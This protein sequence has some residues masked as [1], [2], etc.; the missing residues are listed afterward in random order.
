MYN[1]IQR[2]YQRIS[3]YINVYQ[4]TFI[5]IYIYPQ[6]YQ[7]HGTFQVRHPDTAASSQGRPQT[8]AK[9]RRCAK[10]KRLGCRCW[11]YVEPTKDEK[12]MGFFTIIDNIIK[13]KNIYI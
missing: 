9:P 4:R 1:N 10:Q 12:H 2:D 6:K 11:S 5:Y 3:T 13:G 8:P 7:I